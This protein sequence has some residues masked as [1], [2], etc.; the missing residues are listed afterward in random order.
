MGSVV[1]GFFFGSSQTG[2][3]QPQEGLAKFDSVRKIKNL[4]IFCRLT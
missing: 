4:S 1:A 2:D 3:D